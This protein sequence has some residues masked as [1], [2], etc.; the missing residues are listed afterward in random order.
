MFNPAMLDGCDRMLL[1][2]SLVES[3]ICK[4]PLEILP[5][6]PVPAG[7]SV[8]SWEIYLELGFS[9]NVLRRTSRRALAAR[10]TLGV[11]FVGVQVL[12]EDYLVM[13]LVIKQF[14]GYRPNHHQSQSARP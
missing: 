8:I 7:S 5:F 14:V 2:R 13:F 9:T 1:T 3:D 10:R 4:R 11:V 6:L 12:D